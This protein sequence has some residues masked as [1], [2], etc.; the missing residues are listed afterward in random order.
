MSH[1]QEAFGRGTGATARDGHPA[2]VEAT[3]ACEAI[4]NGG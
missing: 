1:N 2:A 3:A 4:L